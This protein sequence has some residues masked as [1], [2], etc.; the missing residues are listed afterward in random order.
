MTE[1]TRTWRPRRFGRAMAWVYLLGFLAAVV[2]GAIVVALDGEPGLLVAS[3]LGGL[4]SPLVSVLGGLRAFVSADAEGVHVQN[5]RRR[6]D[7]AWRRSWRCVPAITGWSSRHVST[8][9]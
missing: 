7:L 5:P 4:P 6:Y 3:V 8:R 2:A 1:V 9:W